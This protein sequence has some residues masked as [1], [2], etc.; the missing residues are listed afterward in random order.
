M[1]L[2]P[3]LADRYEPG[4]TSSS[5]S[6][7]VLLGTRTPSDGEP[8]LWQH[9]GPPVRRTRRGGPK[10]LHLMA[11]RRAARQVDGD[12]QTALGTGGSDRSPAVRL[13]DGAD[14]RQAEAGATT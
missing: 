12:G 8:P 3:L 5:P 6:S 13:C 9:R 7:P 4:A 1:H 2:G 11:R 14:D 10:G